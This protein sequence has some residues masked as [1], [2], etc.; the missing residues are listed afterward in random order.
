MCVVVGSCL[1]CCYVDLFYQI[2]SKQV[3]EGYQYQVDGVVVVDKGFYVVVQVGGD[4]IL[5]NWVEDND[6]IVFYVQ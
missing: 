4:Y 2:L 3:V 5:V 1:V 6:C